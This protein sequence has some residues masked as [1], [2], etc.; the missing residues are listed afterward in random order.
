MATSV[1]LDA[2][3][4]TELEAAGV[5]L[6]SWTWAEQRRLDHQAVVGAIKSLE[7]EQYVTAAAVS[8]DFWQLTPEAAGYLE[9]GSPEA[10]LFHAVPDA[11]IDDR[12]MDALFTKEFVSIAKGKCMQRKWIAKD[13]QT[14]LYVKSVS[15]ARVAAVGAVMLTLSWGGVRRRTC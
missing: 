4:L 14:G 12:G 9:K 1:D 3:L 7:A 2:Q 15:R 6:D 11:G 8:L 10:Q 5:S 13:K